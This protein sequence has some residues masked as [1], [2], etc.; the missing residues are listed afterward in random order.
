MEVDVIRFT[1]SATIIKCLDNHF[2]WYGVPVGLRSDNGPNF[3]S[4]EI[5][6]YLEKMGIIHRHTT[7][8]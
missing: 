8:G 4:E 1:T 6:K 5:K 2:A 7:K 3:V